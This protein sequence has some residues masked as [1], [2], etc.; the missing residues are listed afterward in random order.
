MARKDRI[1]SFL[2]ENENNREWTTM[3]I[4]SALGIDRAN[5]SRELNHFVRQGMIEK[6]K[7]RPV[8]Y[9][10]A[11]KV[12][13][14]EG[15]TTN[16]EVFQCITGNEGSMKTPI[17]QAKSSI[18]YPPKG[19][20]C[21]IT[22][23]TGTGKTLFVHTM[24]Q[25]AKEKELIAKEK[26]LTVFNCADYANNTELLMSHLFGYVKGAFTG[27]EKTTD[28]LIQQADGGML[29]LDEVHRLPPEGQEMIFYF[30]DHGTYSRLGEVD[31]NNHADVRVVCATTDDPNSS[32]LSTFTRRIPIMIHL[33]SFHERPA[34]EQI[35]LLK[36]MLQMEA[37]RI[38]RHFELNEEVAKALIGSVDYGNV[39]QLKS[40]IQ[41]VC[42]RGFLNHMDEEVIPLTMELLTPQIKEGVVKLKNQHQ[43]YMEI[44]RRLESV[45]HIHPTMEALP[46]TDDYE[47]PNNLYELIDQK[48]SILKDEGMD[49]EAINRF[50]T[51][52]INIYWK[53]VYQKRTVE[54]EK[55]LQDIV[56]DSLI[57]ITKQLKEVLEQQF[58]QTLSP[59]FVYAMSLHLSS[60]MKRL[61]TGEAITQ[62]SPTIL[63]MVQDYPKELE[64]AK[65]MKSFLESHY[66]FH[67]PQSEIYYLATLL[68]SLNT[69]G[70]DNHIGVVVATHGNSTA[71]S[72]V[73]A[74]SQLL[75]IHHLESFDMTL[76]MRPNEALHGIC[77]KIEQVNRGRGVLLLVDMGSLSTFN[78]KIIE[79]TGIEVRTIDMVTTAM[80]LEAGRKTAMANVGLDNIYEDLRRFKGYSHT[81]SNFTKNELNFGIDYRKK[82]IIT[83]CSTGEGTAKTLEKLL[84]DLMTEKQEEEITILPISLVNMEERIK[85]IEK[86]YQIVASV[87]IK[88]PN[89][90]V[91]HLTLEQLLRG[92]GE[93]LLTYLSKETDAQ[94]VQGTMNMTLE[95]LEEYVSR[96]YTFINPRKIIPI[97]WEY[98]DYLERHHLPLSSGKRLNLITHLAGAIERSLLHDEINISLSEKKTL[99][100]HRY[101][102]LVK[103]LNDFLQE[104]LNLQLSD[105]E[106][107]YVTQMIDT[108]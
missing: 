99:H 34:K 83:I 95:Q 12:K 3:E 62:V 9:F 13:T 105:S 25:F 30:M 64:M 50:I 33:P 81:A 42:A 10:L 73:N 48:V 86:D 7:T 79:M 27:A 69:E 52:D 78:K 85:E 17:E 76:D 84:H 8:R 74:V 21:L 108:E 49:K 38:N 61:E 56:D 59:D 103:K 104:R 29:F 97:L 39:G 31:K 71:T 37:S 32:L 53:S 23:Q 35:D 89:L 28:G 77:Q 60:F 4:A 107:Y 101:Y 51:T 67:V 16:Q 66:P 22:G 98:C 58:D 5:V 57:E 55:S 45:L 82:A 94:I 40:N 87:G 106:L 2:K 36:K 44:S 41:L 18:L 19:L 43:L 92:E 102:H 75:N 11:N 47:L 24:F 65:R 93:E 96:Y 88:K 91:P 15:V 14:K 1:L 100:S 46:P 63:E 70:Q 72:M 80:V 68:V 26:E 90:S 54:A 20:N 6:T